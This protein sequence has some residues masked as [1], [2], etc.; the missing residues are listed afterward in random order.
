MISGTGLSNTL[1]EVSISNV[2][3]NFIQIQNSVGLTTK[4]SAV[5]KADAYGLGAIEVVTG[6]LF[7]GCTD[8]WVANL[9]EAL[10]L[11]EGL[12][13]KLQNHDPI[14]Y[15]PNMSL[16]AYNA[17]YDDNKADA[18]RVKHTYN[19]YLL[20]GILTKEEAEACIRYNL[21]PVLNSIEQIHVFNDVCK[22]FIN[23]N[24]IGH[25]RENS[26]DNNRAYNSN[27]DLTSLTNVVRAVLSIDVGICRLGLFEDELEKLLTYPEVF[28]SITWQYIMGH[29]SCSD[30][31]THTHNEKQLALLQHRVA[32][33]RA[34]SKQPIKVT[35]ANSAGLA[36]GQ[37]YYFDLVRIGCL[38]YGINPMSDAT[39]LKQMFSI[40]NVV[41]LKARVLQRK[42]L[43]SP[44]YVGYGATHHI[45]TG[46][47]VFVVENGY[48]DGNLNSSFSNVWC[49]VGEHTL[50]VIGRISMDLCTIDA[51][52]LP[53]D[54]FQK[55]D[56]VEF[57][58]INDFTNLAAMAPHNTLTSIAS[59]HKKVYC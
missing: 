53:H 8:F 32:R 40:L 24:K 43:T 18:L 13:I 44:Q 5:V 14:L 11:V 29:L 58:T 20:H 45:T 22:E 46:S 36:L 23:S 49:S 17:P 34:I 38:L 16:G 55:A 19:I 1:I 15:R 9:N 30:V 21:I 42:M 54:V 2:V 25:Y 56:H 27:T 47:K 52:S 26:D 3:A 48:A 4:C 7:A 51:S 33:F 31:K 12:R 59:R 28:S 10:A 50:P 39:N 37:R 35:L 57:R 6:L 41:K